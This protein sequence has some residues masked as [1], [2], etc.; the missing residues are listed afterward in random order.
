[1]TRMATSLS[2]TF[3]GRR[4]AHGA[5]GHSMGNTGPESTVP[6]AA[7]GAG[8]ARLSTPQ[9]AVHCLGAPKTCWA[10]AGAG[11]GRA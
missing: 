8:G 11:E 5:G 2:R 9:S 10:G 1:M 7:S 6:R 3:L 4:S